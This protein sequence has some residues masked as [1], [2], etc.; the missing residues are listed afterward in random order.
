MSAMTHSFGKS[1]AITYQA[2]S[3]PISLHAELVADISTL[4]QGNEPVQM[5]ASSSAHKP[6][7]AIAASGLFFIWEAIVSISYVAVEA[8]G[9]EPGAEL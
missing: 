3:A 9:A 7:A 5:E 2:I 6:A 1:T 8:A 4:E